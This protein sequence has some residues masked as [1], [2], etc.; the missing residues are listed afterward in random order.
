MPFGLHKQ[1]IVI[2][3]REGGAPAFWMDHVEIAL[4][5]RAQVE[6]LEEGLELTMFGR[7]DVVAERVQRA[8]TSALGPG[9]EPALEVGPAASRAFR[10]S[11]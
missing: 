1:T 3:P 2:A 9:W 5:G 10:S 8:L 6:R 7:P 11:A 4:L